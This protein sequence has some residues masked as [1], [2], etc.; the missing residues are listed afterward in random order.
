[1]GAHSL[2]PQKLRF[3]RKKKGKRKKNGQFP[4]WCDT[5]SHRC[6]QEDLRGGCHGDSDGDQEDFGGRWT[7]KQ[8][9]LH[10]SLAEQS[11]SCNPVSQGRGAKCPRCPRLCH[12]RNSVDRPLLAQ[13]QQGHMARPV[14]RRGWRQTET[15]PCSP[16]DPSSPRFQ[17][18]PPALQP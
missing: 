13:G 8:E 4:V 16:K 3:Q 7:V 6:M 18:E 2:T 9:S 5:C 11:V 14:E 15:F 1:M 12:T 17:P 10:Y